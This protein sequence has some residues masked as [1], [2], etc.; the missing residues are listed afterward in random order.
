MLPHRLLHSEGDGWTMVYTPA[1]EQT[2][3]Q[4]P[5]LLSREPQTASA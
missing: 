4:L 2:A 3:L 5:R 1:N